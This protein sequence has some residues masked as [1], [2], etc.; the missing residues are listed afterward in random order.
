VKTLEQQVN[1]QWQKFL[2]RWPITQ[3]REVKKLVRELL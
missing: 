2:R 1:E 3:H